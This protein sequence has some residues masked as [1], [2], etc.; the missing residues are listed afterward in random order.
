[1]M[2]KLQKHNF[3]DQLFKV[4]SSK[5][6]SRIEPDKKPPKKK[7]AVQAKEEDIVMSSEEEQS[8]STAESKRK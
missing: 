2:T 1:M 4:L 3:D 5:P 7:K 6:Y 8:K